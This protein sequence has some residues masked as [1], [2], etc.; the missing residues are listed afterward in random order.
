[1]GSIQQKLEKSALGE[2][3]RS[4]P[5]LKEFIRNG[6][7]VSLHTPRSPDQQSIHLHPLLLPPSQS[8]PEML[9]D[10]P[11]FSDNFTTPKEILAIQQFL[12]QNTGL[13]YHK[14]TE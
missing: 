12:L 5:R 7:H 2:K 9:F 4:G 1:M 8:A 11:F 13:R 3:E 10:A 6:D 14:T